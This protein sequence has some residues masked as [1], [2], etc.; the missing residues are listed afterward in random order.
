MSSRLPASTL[1]VTGRDVHVMVPWAASLSE[2]C[3]RGLPLLDDPLTFVN[4]HALLKRLG[5]QQWLR[6]DEYALNTPHERIWAQA[7]GWPAGETSMI[8]LAAHQARADGL[9]VGRDAW[10]LF[11]PC[12]WLMGHDHL[13]LL[14][15]DELALTEGEAREVFEAVSPLFEDEGWRLRWG[16][17]TRW[18]VSHESLANLPTAS[19]DRVLGRNPDLWMPDHPQAKLIKRL[20]SEVQMLLYQH[21]LNEERQARGAYSVNSF[22]LS[23]CGRLPES[24]APTE[25]LQVLDGPR[26]ALLHGDMDQWLQ[27]WRALE[28][29][30]FGPLLDALNQ[31]RN[32]RLS[33]C[34]ERHAVTLSTP[35]HDHWWQSAWHATV[36]RLTQQAPTPAALLAQL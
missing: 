3:E 16:S 24:G 19:L 26:Q 8:P 9:D 22:W 33:L 25:S 27:S 2:G 17:N 35:R 15:P 10:G 7:Q 13:T 36:R 1:D 4:L 14:H 28:N 12:H 18:Y 32:M 31:G 20:Q 5:A 23:G 30:A 34:G 21:P 6:G 11:T 29:E